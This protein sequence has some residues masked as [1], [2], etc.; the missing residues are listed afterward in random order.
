MDVRPAGWCPEGLIC[1]W[2]WS[3]GPGM[4]TCPP[5]PVLS[6]ATLVTRVLVQKKAQVCLLLVSESSL[7]SASKVE[8]LILAPGTLRVQQ[9][10]FLQLTAQQPSG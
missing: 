10:L 1:C 4:A 2:R 5:L 3:E 8:G 6:Q 9:L 7:L